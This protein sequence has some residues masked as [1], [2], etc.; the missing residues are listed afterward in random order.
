MGL[1]QNYVLPFGPYNRQSAK[2]RRRR[3]TNVIL[4]ARSR[5]SPFIVNLRRTNFSS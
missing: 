3:T 2:W 1:A 5:S 4:P